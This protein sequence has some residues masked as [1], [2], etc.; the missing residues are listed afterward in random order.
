MGVR[1]PECDELCFNLA[2]NVFS[3][4]LSL[5]LGKGTQ[6]AQVGNSFRDKRSTCKSSVCGLSAGVGL[7]LYGSKVQSRWPR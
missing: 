5:S 1:R 2:N 3:L 4:A 7:F 6:A